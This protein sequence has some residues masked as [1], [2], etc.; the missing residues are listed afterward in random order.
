MKFSLASSALAL[1]SLFAVNAEIHQDFSLKVEGFPPAPEAGVFIHA[2]FNEA[3]EEMQ[4]SL[5]DDI[6]A[7]KTTTKFMNMYTGSGNGRALRGGSRSGGRR[8][9]LIGALISIWYGGGYV[10]D[11]GT[12]QAGFEAA[13]STDFSC[14]LCVEDDDY[15]PYRNLATSNLIWETNMGGVEEAFCNKLKAEPAFAD[16]T[17]CTASAMDGEF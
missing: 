17:L 9:D 15:Y 6:V 8:L 7:T 10:D 13:T 12:S 5:N 4:A 1:S 2:A 11:D 16:I 14:N 3:L